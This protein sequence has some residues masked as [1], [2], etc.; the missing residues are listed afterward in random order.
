MEIIEVWIYHY[1]PERIQIIYIFAIL[2]SNLYRTWGTRCQIVLILIILNTN[3]SK[4]QFFMIMICSFIAIK[5][6]ARQCGQ[7]VRLLTFCQIFEVCVDNL[8]CNK[9]SKLLTIYSTI[10]KPDCFVLNCQNYWQIIPQFLNLI[11]Y[12]ILV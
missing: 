1:G 7:I 2:N 4:S 5:N 12:L 8:F 9:L 3:Q 11:I 10:F 6:I